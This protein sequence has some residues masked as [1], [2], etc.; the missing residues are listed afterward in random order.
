MTII[1]SRLS[2]LGDV[3]IS[4][5]VIQILH[6]Q[7]PNAKIVLITK[8]LNS[9]LFVNF[10]F[11]ELVIPSFNYKHKGILGLLK[12]F[13]ELK[14]KYSPEIFIDLHDVL[15]TKFLRLFFSLTKTKIFKIDKGRKEKRGILKKQKK[16]LL[17]LKTTFQRYID[18]F[19][20]SGLNLSIKTIPDYPVIKSQKIEEL[21]KSEPFIVFA[22]F[23]AHSNKVYPLD[24]S[25]EL[26]NLLAKKIKVYILGAGQ[27]EKEVVEK[28][29]TSNIF[30]LIGKYN[31]QEEIYLMSKSIAVI[32]MD[33][34]NM[35][36]ASLSKANI[37]SIW[38]PTH[39]N[40]GFIPVNN[41]NHTI[42]QKE[43][44]CRPCSIYG[45]KECY[46]KSLECMN[47]EPKFIVEQFF[48]T[49]KIFD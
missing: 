47:I 11:V 24:K 6:E 33:S 20:E 42:I 37:F 29:Q 23:A 48:S 34:A 25:V 21:I 46:K 49:L 38:G 1:I 7:Y 39:P 4:V 12:L 8:N 18:V 22:P 45:N 31:L 3:A 30:S 28:W 41:Q 16:N 2:A 14:K 26:I 36:L 5:P 19:N 43:L 44:N 32:T 9:Q 35:H 13:I 27:K 10:S 40:I 15:R 17:Q